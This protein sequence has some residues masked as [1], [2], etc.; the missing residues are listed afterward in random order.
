ME[1]EINFLEN[2]LDL[3]YD[4]RYTN[5]YN[6]PGVFT[7][8]TFYVDRF[9]ILAG[10]RADHHGDFGWKTTPRML[11]RAEVSDDTDIRFSVGKGFRRVHLFTERVNLLASNRDIII[12]WP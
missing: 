4:G 2:P 7:E 8:G 5:D 1:E 12:D 9:T 11:I 6:I 10:I 3:T